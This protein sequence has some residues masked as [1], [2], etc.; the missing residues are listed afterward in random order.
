[1]GEIDLVL[2]QVAEPPFTTY[3]L[4]IK[5]FFIVGFLSQF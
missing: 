1:M 4:R 2:A 3:S 5:T